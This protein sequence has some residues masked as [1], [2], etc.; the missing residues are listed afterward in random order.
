MQPLVTHNCIEFHDNTSNIMVA[1]PCFLY[2]IFINYITK[3][4]RSNNIHKPGFIFG[5]SKKE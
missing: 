4:N 5:L 3:A 2:T 1:V